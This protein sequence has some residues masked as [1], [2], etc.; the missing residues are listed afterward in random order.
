MTR[1]SNG[2]QPGARLARPIRHLRD[3]NLLAR[4]S[5]FPSSSSPP[6]PFA[7]DFRFVNEGTYLIASVCI[8]RGWPGHLS[9]A[10]SCKDSFVIVTAIT[11][12]GPLANEVDIMLFYPENI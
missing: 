8:D 12:D 3:S 11:L 1:I 4:K 10:N 6:P 9:T 5:H 7:G 2:S